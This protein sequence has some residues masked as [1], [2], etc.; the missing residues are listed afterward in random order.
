MFKN[1][2]VLDCINDQYHGINAHMHAVVQLNC[3]NVRLTRASTWGLVSH[4]TDACAWASRKRNSCAAYAASTFSR[5][6]CK[7][8]SDQ[9]Y[10]LQRPRPPQVKIRSISLDYILDHPVPARHGSRFDPSLLTTSLII[11]SQPAKSRAIE[12]AHVPSRDRVFNGIRSNCNMSTPF[13]IGQSCLIH[14]HSIIMTSKKNYYTLN[15]S[16]QAGLYHNETDSYVSHS[17]G[18]SLAE[19][20]GSSSCDVLA[21]R[22]SDKEACRAAG[23]LRE[24][25][26]A[27]WGRLGALAPKRANHCDTCVDPGAA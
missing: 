19:A 26:R 6:L 23:F 2:T 1:G 9:P 13:A 15:L 7:Q 20:T 25:G 4:N 10:S 16:S 8:L 12:L 27:S 11:Q 24:A 22:I 3:Q 5:S 14:N 18:C 17:C 21:L